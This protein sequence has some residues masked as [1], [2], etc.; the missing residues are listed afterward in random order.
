MFAHRNGQSKTLQ[1]DIE[2][3]W[4]GQMIVVGGYVGTDLSCDSP[5]IYVFNCKVPYRNRRSFSWLTMIVSSLK[6]QNAFNALQG[7]NDQSQQVSQAKALV[8]DKAGLAG[9]YGY[10]VPKVVHDVI[11]GNENGG[12]TVTAPVVTA[13]AGPLKTGSPI[14][15]TVTADGATV[16]QTSG[17]SNYDKGGSGPNIGAI[18]AG[19]VAGVFA[20]LAG[21]LGFCAYVY[22]RQLNLYKDHVATAQRAALAPPGEGTGFL[23]AGEKFSGL[24]SSRG[25]NS[26]SANNNPS[27]GTSAIRGSTSVPYRSDDPRPSDTNSDDGEVYLDQEPSF[28]GV[29]M[30]PVSILFRLLSL[31]G[32]LT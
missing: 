23:A 13:L 21:Y 2:Q 14:T 11:G 1:T 7:S 3:V 20:L 17:A 28:I 9:S 29:M 31:H 12:A 5:G 4:D 10:Q 27:S 32:P 16:T 26:S 24:S 8:G 6:W 18:V 22:R 19:V 25:P 15:Y 30:S